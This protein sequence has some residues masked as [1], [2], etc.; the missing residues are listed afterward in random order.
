[1]NDQNYSYYEALNS[2]DTNTD[3]DFFKPSI[4]DKP[5]TIMQVL[6]ALNSGGVERGTIEISKALASAG[7]KSVVVSNGGSMVK[8]LT[9]TGG[10][11]VNLD[12]GSK[13]PLN[14]ANN[15]LRLKEAV[16]QHDVSLIHARSRMPA[17]ISLNV[18]K[19]TDTTF[20]TTFHGRHNDTNLLKKFYNSVMTRGQR[21]IAI[22]KYIA[23]EITKRH[24][25]NPKQLSI[26]PRGVDT[27]YFNRKTV[28][29][30]RI[31]KLITNWE[32]P[33]N[34]PVIMLPGRVSRW[35]GH[36]LLIESLIKLKDQ[37]FFCVIVGPFNGKEKFKRKIEYLI[38]ANGLCSKVKIVGDCYDMAAAYSVA[39][40]VISA[41]LDPEPFGRTIIEAQA[42]GKLVLASNHG[43]A[44]ESIVEGKTG[45]LYEPRNSAA[46]SDSLKNALSLTEQKRSTISSNAQKHIKEKFST[47]LM[48]MR[49]LSVY[50]EILNFRLIRKN[51]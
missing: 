40:I 25:I 36:E 34:T 14:W 20:M 11:H 35:K 46:L 33:K 50:S 42:M 51:N 39:D 45:W 37:P 23:S 5:P 43:G 18:A 1:M 19:L 13:N 4:G 8:E 24:P 6:P 28:A 38:R 16:Y 49:T 17:W 21:T 3:F 48:C 32:I 30:E 15:Y 26:I 12:I 44:V 29:E 22:S 2:D 47:Q 31:N 7:W 9:N 10:V 27:E 41:S